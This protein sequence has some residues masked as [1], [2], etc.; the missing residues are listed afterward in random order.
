MASAYAVPTTM[1]DLKSY[2][3]GSS[4]GMQQCADSTVLLHITHN[5]LKAKFPELRFDLHVRGSALW[6]LHSSPCSIF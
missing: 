4:S 2:V 5:H 3:T 1:S 6:P